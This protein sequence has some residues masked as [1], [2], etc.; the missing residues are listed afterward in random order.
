MGT[1]API[2]TRPAS[3]RKNFAWTFAGNV[4]LGAS[5][6]AILSLIAKLGNSEMLGQYALAAAVAGPIAM[7]AHLNLRAVLATDIQRRHPFRDYLAVRMMTSAGALCAT[8]LV[9]WIAGY[10]GLVAAVILLMGV[11]L[12][13]ENVSDTYYGLMQRR[14]RMDQIACSMMARGA[15]SVIGVGAVL[16]STGSLVLSVIAPVIVRIAVLLAYD[17]PVGSAGES[18]GGSGGSSRLAIF[19]MALP[20]GVVLMLVS[21]TTNVPRYA[22]EH[23][24]GAS[25]LGVFAAVA[26]FINAG[27]AVVGALG[28]SAMPRLAIYFSQRDLKR[29]RQLTVRLIALSFALGV[30]G[31]VGAAVLGRFLL[32]VMYRP[33]YSAYQVLFVGVMCAGVLC[34]VSVM[35]GYVLTSARSFR[36]QLPLQVAAVTAAALASWFLVPTHGLSGAAIAIALAFGVRIAGATLIL[37]YAMKNI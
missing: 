11:W 35:M 9:A 16:W 10:R 14:E 7:L 2:E 34:Y 33:E 22:I 17:R 24:H 15:L 37:R 29:F 31:V 27:S 26:S 25:E 21:L 8:G 5:Q 1:S 3:L 6:W 13:A 4:V 36:P 32:R 12:G 19:R 20:L 30:M 18:V 28:Q 23:F